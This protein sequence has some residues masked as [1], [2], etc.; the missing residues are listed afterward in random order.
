MPRPS[1]TTSPGSR[2]E[3]AMTATPTT[4]AALTPRRRRR[5]PLGANPLG[6]LFSAPYLA[7]VIV[8]FAFPLGFSVY[9]AFH[10]YFFTAPG[11]E[12]DHPFVGF[13]NFRNVLTDPA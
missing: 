10:D 8:V 7:F 9:M 11:Y 4:P 6:L 1:S 3:H 5:R 13:D 12:V 2:R